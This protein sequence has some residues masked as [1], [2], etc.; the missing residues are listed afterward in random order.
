MPSRPDP[1]LVTLLCLSLGS[2]T[3]NPVPSD[4]NASYG[5]YADAKA[6]DKLMRMNYDIHVGAIIGL[7]AK[8]LMF[9]ISLIC[10]PACHRRVSLVGTA[11]QRKGET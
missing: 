4:S 3:E 11:E 1:R 9:F 7:P 5:R 8:I 10:K 6:P 2:C